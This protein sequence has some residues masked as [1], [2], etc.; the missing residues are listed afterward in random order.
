MRKDVI[1]MRGL[2]FW[3]WESDTEDERQRAIGD[4]IAS[5]CVK[6]DRIVRRRCDKDDGLNSEH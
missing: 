5:C 3:A 2:F 6:L 1:S 4:K